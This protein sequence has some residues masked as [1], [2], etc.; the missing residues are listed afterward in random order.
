MNQGQTN[1]L[2][3]SSE[4][5]W[6]LCRFLQ[7]SQRSPAASSST[8]PLFSWKTRWQRLL[9]SLQCPP[10]AGLPGTHPYPALPPLLCTAVFSGACPPSQA[11]APPHWLGVPGGFTQRWAKGE[12]RRERT[13]LEMKGAWCV[14][15]TT[16]TGGPGGPAAPGSPLGPTTP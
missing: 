6:A 13:I 15:L 1:H 10:W 5:S 12:R 3:S 7:G 9:P 8:P 11:E 2:C 16:L 4:P 14:L